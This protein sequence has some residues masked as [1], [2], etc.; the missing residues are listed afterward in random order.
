MLA[1]FGNLEGS[2]HVLSNRMR[3]AFSFSTPVAE[4]DSEEG[5]E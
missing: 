3:F 4:N 1:S 2:S 5:G